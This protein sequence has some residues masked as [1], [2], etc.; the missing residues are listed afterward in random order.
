MV[1]RSTQR[2]GFQSQNPC[3][4]KRFSQK[5][6]KKLRARRFSSAEHFYLHT[7]FGFLLRGLMGSAQRYVRERHVPSPS[8]CT[9]FPHPYAVLAWP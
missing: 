2:A 3:T 1:V 4:F 5:A 6:D 7:F 8:Q 9:A